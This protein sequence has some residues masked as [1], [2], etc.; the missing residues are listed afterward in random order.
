MK[1]RPLV[2]VHPELRNANN[3]HQPLNSTSQRVERG[4]CMLQSALCCNK[5]LPM[6]AALLPPCM[7]QPTVWNPKKGR[8]A[9]HRALS[10]TDINT[11]RGAF[12][13]TQIS[14]Q[15][16]TAGTCSCHLSGHKHSY[17]R[18]ACPSISIGLID[19]SFSS[20]K[21]HHLNQQQKHTAITRQMLRSHVTLHRWCCHGTIC[22]SKLTVAT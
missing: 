5:I 16:S 12:P 8:T 11:C 4:P 22:G 2:A 18:R 10:K 6:A 14:W 7:R 9:K 17:A 1:G 3:K 19:V 20:N 21:Q 13:A 15:R